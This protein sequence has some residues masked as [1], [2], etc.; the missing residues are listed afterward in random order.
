[1]MCKES[2]ASRV[3]LTL[4]TSRGSPGLHPTLASS[5]VCLPRSAADR[6]RK[7][8]MEAK[9]FSNSQPRKA[10]PQS[11]LRPVIISEC[12]SAQT[13]NQPKPHGHKTFPSLPSPR[14]F[15]RHASPTLT[16]CRGW[17]L[18]RPGPRGGYLW[19]FTCVRVMCQNAA[20]GALSSRTRA[21]QGGNRAALL[22]VVKRTRARI[23]YHDIDVR[24]GASR[25]GEASKQAPTSTQAVAWRVEL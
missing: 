24:N 11:Q 17:R 6:T 5:P 14:L 19:I 15:A 7:V 4:V 22:D 3:N 21:C 12:T 18:E 8:T 20:G 1:M 9:Q 2:R 25:Q 13:T 23:L 16:G 10:F